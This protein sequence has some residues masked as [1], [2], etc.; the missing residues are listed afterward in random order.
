MAG[1]S[2]GASSGRSAG[3]SLGEREAGFDLAMC[4]E[5]TRQRGVTELGNVPRSSSIACILIILDLYLCYS[6][7]HYQHG[8]DEYDH[9]HRH[10]I[11]C[12]EFGCGQYCSC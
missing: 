10:D 3:A 2:G 1:A 4:E 12:R 5:T 11:I 8:D 7:H 9:K 6:C